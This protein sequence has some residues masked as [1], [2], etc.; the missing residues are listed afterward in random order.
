MNT[1]ILGK[2]RAVLRVIDSISEYTAMM[3]RW[4]ALALVLVMSY[5]VIMRYVFGTSNIWAH[6]LPMM[7]G[8]SL[9][10]LGYAYVQ[11]YRG[12]IR[13]DILYARLSRRGRAIIDVFGALVFLFPIMIIVIYA[14]IMAAEFAWVRDERWTLS[15]WF[16]PLAPL[17]TVIAAGFCLLLLQSGAQFIRDL[18]ILIRNKPYD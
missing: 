10:A 8:A 9:Y 12:H 2:M 17:R 6:E 15:I 13:V 4:L 1:P 7:L 11:R 16:P 3:G 18:H 5:E 14:S